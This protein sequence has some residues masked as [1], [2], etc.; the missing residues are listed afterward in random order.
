MEPVRPYKAS[1]IARQLSVRTCCCRSTMDISQSTTATVDRGPAQ[2]AVNAIRA[3][4]GDAPAEMRKAY[5]KL[6]VDK[7]IVSR[8]EIHIS[9]PKG[10]LANAAVIPF[11]ER[12]E[13]VI[14]F[15][16]AWRAMRYEINNWNYMKFL[17][18]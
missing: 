17:S 10:A 7:V 6:F 9:G 15:V 18:Q 11:P 16:R 1:E 3:G 4:L 8:S 14:T 5:I 2:Q 12:P 13:E